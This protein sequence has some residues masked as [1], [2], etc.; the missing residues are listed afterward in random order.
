MTSPLLVGIYSNGSL[1]RKIETDER[2][3][4]AL[5]CILDEISN[6]Y[7]IKK[8]IYANTPG[9]F[10]GLK[11]AY[12]VLKTFSIIKNCDFFAISGF[13]LTNNMP[14]KANKILSFVKDK[15][16]VV[17][18][19]VENANLSLPLNL[20]NLKLNSDTLPNYVI[21]AV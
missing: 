21:Q 9:S 2:V 17:L 4:E 3:S 8:I 12:V 14:I 11:V 6:S 13:E 5:V 20:E 1:I 15:D 7:D 10:M 19:K 16:D 18:K